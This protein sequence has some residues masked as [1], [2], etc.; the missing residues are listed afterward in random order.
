MSHQLSL[1]QIAALSGYGAG[2]A[3]GQILFKLAS[4]PTEA[5]TGGRLSSLLAN[6]LF[7]GALAIYF[8]LSVGWVLILRA[9]PLS[10]AYPFTALS[11]V[12]VSVLS[13]IIFRE[14]ISP[15]LILELVAILCGLI[16][17]AE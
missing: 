7:V 2:M 14:P 3:A 17:V 16:L 10:R 13:N 5:T 11:F 12:L 9:T 8:G 15:R 4:V 1:I 6:G